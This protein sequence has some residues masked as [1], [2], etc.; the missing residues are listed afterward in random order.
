MISYDGKDKLYTKLVCKT[1]SQPNVLADQIGG[2]GITLVQENLFTDLPSLQS[3][4]P[5]DS[6]SISVLDKASFT[7]SG[8]SDITIWL[9][10]YFVPAKTSNYKFDLKSNSHAILFV[11][12]DQTSQAKSVI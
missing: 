12:D 2:R 6:A 7:D 10:G 8:N 9:K 1:S 3:S 11:S 4:T 5:T